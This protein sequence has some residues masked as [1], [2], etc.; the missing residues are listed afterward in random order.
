MKEFD[1]LHG[2]LSLMVRNTDISA[3]ET[4]NESGDEVLPNPY[5][6]PG[7]GEELPKLH[8]PSDGMHQA[9]FAIEYSKRFIREVG[10]VICE[11]GMV[12]MALASDAVLHLCTP[13]V[14]ANPA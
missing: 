11:V 2:S 12:E 8:P 13:T 1:P 10:V 7:E 4:E 5:M 9:L 6:I 14:C 3:F